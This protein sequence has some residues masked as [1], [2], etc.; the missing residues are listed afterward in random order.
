MNLINNL[1]GGHCFGSSRTRRITGGKVITFKLDHPIFDGGMRCCMFLKCF[2]QNGVNFLRRL[3]LQENNLMTVCASM[4][5]KLRSSL[6]MPPFSLCNKKRLAIWHMNRPIFPTTLSIPSYNVEK[7]VGLRTYQHPLICLFSLTTLDSSI[8]FQASNYLK[9]SIGCKL[10]IV[11]SSEC[12]VTCSTCGTVHK[13]R[14]WLCQYVTFALLKQ[15][16]QRSW[17][18]CQ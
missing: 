3:A 18:L 14:N 2:C 12:A 9:C 6:A 1:W 16:W 15:C 13:K 11:G 17:I 8:Q 10:K 7:W 5:L 4:L